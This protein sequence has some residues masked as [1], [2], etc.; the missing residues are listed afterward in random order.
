MGDVVVVVKSGRSSGS[1]MGNLEVRGARVRWLRLV[2]D[3]F[4]RRASVACLV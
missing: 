4:F 1:V 3:L 2:C